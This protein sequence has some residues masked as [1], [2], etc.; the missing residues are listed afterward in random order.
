MCSK[1]NTVSPKFWLQRDLKFVYKIN[2]QISQFFY[3]SGNTVYDLPE[4]VKEGGIFLS[5]YNDAAI[6]SWLDIIGSQLKK[7]KT[8]N[9][10]RGS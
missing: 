4:D 10:I 7:K 5:H 6:Y 9:T 8:I 2:S 1:W 3:T